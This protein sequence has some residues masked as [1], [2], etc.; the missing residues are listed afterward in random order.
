MPRSFNFIESMNM[1][2]AVSG[3]YISRKDV[4]EYFYKTFD[5]DKMFEP[6]ELKQIVRELTTGKKRI[7]STIDNNNIWGQRKNP[8]RPDDDRVKGSDDENVK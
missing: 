4:R 7:T 3:T 6:E 5:Q 1:V 2:S 8:K